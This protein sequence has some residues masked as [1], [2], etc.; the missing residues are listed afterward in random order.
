MRRSGEGLRGDAE[1]KRD[2]VVHL[3]L[4]ENLRSLGDQTRVSS[5][6]QL[7]DPLHSLRER[8]GRAQAQALT[9]GMAVMEMKHPGAPHLHR[10]HGVRKTPGVAE[11]GKAHDGDDSH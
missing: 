11:I 8:A 2:E 5:Q 3:T 1:T 9:A 10:A 7:R 4:A 6:V